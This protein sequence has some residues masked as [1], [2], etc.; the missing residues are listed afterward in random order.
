MVKGANIEGAGVVIAGQEFGL[1][2]TL[3]SDTQES[4]HRHWVAGKSEQTF[5]RRKVRTDFGSQESQNRLWVAGKLEQMLGW[6]KVRTDFGLQESQN[7]RTM[8]RA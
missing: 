5:E 7:K 1:G 2:E 6:R 3:E 8:S 4:Q